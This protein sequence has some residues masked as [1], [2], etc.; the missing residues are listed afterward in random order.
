LIFLDK[1]PVDK[2]IAQINSIFI[3]III[4]PPT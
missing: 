1:I 2:P 3:R 4:I